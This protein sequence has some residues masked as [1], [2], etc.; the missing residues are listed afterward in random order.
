M[1]ANL[2]TQTLQFVFGARP[3]LVADIQKAAGS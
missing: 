3:D 2:D 1:A